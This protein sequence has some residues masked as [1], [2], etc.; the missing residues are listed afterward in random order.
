MVR[1]RRYPHRTIGVVIGNL[2]SPILKASDLIRDY[3]L[4]LVCE[5]GTGYGG[6]LADLIANNPGVPY[7]GCD[8]DEAAVESVRARLPGINVSLED[9]R[10]FLQ[11][12]LPALDRRTLFYLDAHG[13]ADGE[14][15]FPLLRE[16]E[17]IAAFKPNVAL[18]VIVCDDIRVI[19]DEANPRFWPGE[20]GPPH[21][22]DEHPWAAYTMPFRQTHE[23]RVVLDEEGYLVLLPR[24]ML[25]QRVRE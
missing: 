22:R 8:T 3:G 25:A 19:A 12:T 1:R 4:E 18:D 20:L 11:R 9:S 21:V 15:G 6:P 5:T 16:L 17:L 7:I 10:A 23:V 14:D 24:T 2:A 13:W